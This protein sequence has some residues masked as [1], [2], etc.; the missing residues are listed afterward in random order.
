MEMESPPLK[1]FDK[2]DTCLNSLITSCSC[3]MLMKPDFVFAFRR[4]WTRQ[5]SY[6]C[7]E[8]TFLKSSLELC[9]SKINAFL[10]LSAMRICLFT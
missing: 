10:S 5:Q 7:F 4:C 3:R 9:L 1:P 8:N 2:V 6:S